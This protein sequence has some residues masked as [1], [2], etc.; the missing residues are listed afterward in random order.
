MHVLPFAVRR[1]WTPLRTKRESRA[2]GQGR[3][4]QAL[5]EKLS[6][7]RLVIAGFFVV[8]DARTSNASF[9]LFATLPA[10]VG[11]FEQ[12]GAAILAES[13]TECTAH[14]ALTVDAA[15]APLLHILSA[16]H[17]AGST[18]LDCG[19]R[20]DAQPVT[21]DVGCHTLKNAVSVSAANRGSARFID[22]QANLTAGSAVRRISQ[23]VDAAIGTT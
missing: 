1:A 7:F 17:A 23:Q 21:Q 22:R 5:L 15:W 16:R 9:A 14:D 3:P 8:G 2:R 19:H 11:V 12:V 13:T 6:W 20:V 18:V 4:S 10:I